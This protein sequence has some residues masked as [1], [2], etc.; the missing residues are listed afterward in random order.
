MEQPAASLTI[1]G[2]YLRS[3]FDF[4]KVSRIAGLFDVVSEVRAVAHVHGL[5]YS[6]VEF[7]EETIGMDARLWVFATPVD[8]EFLELTLVTQ[9]RAVRKPGRFFAG[10]GFLPM[11]L[12]RRLM[13]RFLLAEERRYVMQDVVIWER[14]RYRSPPRLC[15]ADGPIGKYRLS[16]SSVLRDILCLL[17]L[18]PRMDG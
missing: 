18:G 4:R 12:R 16:C 13:S 3:A 14:K 5:G 15:R 2:A 6:L 1:D 17:S 11:K 8:G 9:V 10:M 7:H